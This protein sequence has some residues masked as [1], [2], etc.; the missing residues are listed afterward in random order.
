MRLDA[1]APTTA[2]VVGLGL[3]TILL[4]PQSIAV[5]GFPISG[6]GIGPIAASRSIRR[7]DTCFRSQRYTFLST[8]NIRAQ[9][10]VI[11]INT[12]LSS[13]SSSGDD[14]DIIDAVVEDKTAGLT[15]PD[16]E[17]TSVRSTKRDCILHCLLSIVHLFATH[18]DFR[19]NNY[20][21]LTSIL[22]LKY[23]HFNHITGKDTKTRRVQKSTPGPS[24]PKS[25]RLQMAFGTLQ[26]ERG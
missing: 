16:E 25:H 24:L 17:N 6:I 26:K 12:R 9:H 22:P 1:I 20:Q 15:L 21:Y 5:N 11:S 18:I 8:N 19:L 3:S 13:S 2:T 4:T 23:K 7:H 14:G 10:D